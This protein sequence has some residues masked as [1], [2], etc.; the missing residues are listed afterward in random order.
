MSYT[1]THTDTNTHTHTHTHVQLHQYTMQI[2]VDQERLTTVA[3][4]H[5]Q[6]HGWSEDPRYGVL[7]VN[8]VFAKDVLSHIGLFLDVLILWTHMFAEVLLP[9]NWS[10]HHLSVVYVLWP[11]LWSALGLDQGR[12]KRWIRC[13]E[14]IYYRCHGSV[15]KT[16]LGMKKNL[17]ILD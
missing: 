14:S 16:D 9:I 3:K 13:D 4:K 5:E 8:H 17:H 15:W 12:L 1:Q 11:A 7:F 10:V 6:V 2:L